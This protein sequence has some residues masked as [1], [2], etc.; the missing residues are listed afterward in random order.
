[1][2]CFGDTLFPIPAI[3]RLNG[4]LQRVQITHAFA[5]LIDQ[6]NDVCHAGTGSNKDCGV[7]IQ[8]RLLRNIC[9][10][11]VLLQLQGAIVGFFESGQD[12]QKR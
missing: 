11:Q 12:L 7:L 8:Q 3:L 5:V 6:R 1:M 9:Q 2:Q 10:A 4:A